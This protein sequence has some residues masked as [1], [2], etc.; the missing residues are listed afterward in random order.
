MMGATQRMR[1]LLPGLYRPEN[2]DEGLLARYLDTVAGALQ[3]ITNEVGEVLRSHWLPTADRAHFHAFFNRSRELRGDPPPDPAKIVDHAFVHDLARLA[4]LLPLPPWRE[5]PAL[6]ETAENYRLRIARHVRLYREGLGTLGALRR[7]IEA[8]LPPDLELPPAEQDRPFEL[9][10]YAPIVHRSLAVTAR[11]EPEDLVGPLMRWTMDNDGLAATAPT[12]YIQGVEPVVGATAA[13]ENPVIELLGAQDQPSLGIAYSGTLGPGE[14]LRL[15]PATSSWL[16]LAEGL[17]WARATGDDST[18]AN[19]TAPG[20]WRRVEDGPETAVEALLQTHDRAL[21][22]ATTESGEGTLWRLDGHGWAPVLGS[23]PVVHCL[24]EDGPSLLVGTAEG[25]LRVAL[26]PDPPGAFEAAPVPGLDG[27]AVHA[28]L[29]ADENTWYLGTS[30]GLARLEESGEATAIG[31]HADL[32]TEVAVYALAHDSA[33]TLF[34]GTELGCLQLEKV[35]GSWFWYSGATAT[36]QEPEWGE[37]ALDENGN[38]PALPDPEEIFLPPVRAIYRGPDASLWLGTDNGIA[39]YRARPVRGITYETVL[40]A[41]PDLSQGPVS[42]IAEDA[43]GRVWFATNRG[44]L[45]FD[46][47][48]WWQANDSGWQTLGAASHLYHRSEETGEEIDEETGEEVTE[49]A[50]EETGG[51]SVSDSRVVSRGSWRFNRAGGRWQRW[52]KEGWRSYINEPRTESGVAV[53]ALAWTDEVQA[54]RGAWDGTTLT[55]PTEVPTDQLRMRVKPRTDLIVDGGIPSVPRLPT[56]ES[57]WRYLALE[58]AADPADALGSEDLPAW[59]IEG[60]LLPPSPDAAPWPGRFDLPKPPP[61]SSFDE[62][63]FAFEPAARVWLTWRARRP[64]TVLARLR[65]R[66]PEEDID[67]AIIERVWQG[68]QQ[69]RPAGV[70]L[71]LAVDETIVRG[72]EH[73]TDE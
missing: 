59:T 69:V 1:D 58:P 35:T 70:H 21:W 16:G 3:A 51:D 40:E 37:L 20:P 48:D 50:G 14:T 42:A 53:R 62:S 56:G 17:L 33:G 6:R 54:H 63:V 49:D 10:E 47:R 5:P 8:Q 4:A 39:R 11:G 2:G 30:R 27:V 7:M 64:L 72:G 31:V 29:A 34:M 18:D 45:R 61:V 25:V 38:P 22:A 55:E 52:H 43:R 46:G 71:A 57:Q 23:L 32:G 60:R 12:I 26:F 19:P 28:L 41:F 66:R 15:R 44:L 9:E 65:K 67:P 73:G 13:T 24:A 36:E 68:L